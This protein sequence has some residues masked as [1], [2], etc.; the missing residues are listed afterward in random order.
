MRAP[1]Y[2]KDL[3]ARRR[4]GE[5]IGL[6][7]V[8]VH[9]W[10]GGRGVCRAPWRGARGR[11]DDTLP[12]EL[13]WSCAVALDCLVSWRLDAG[14]FRCRL[15]MLQA[16]GAASLW[17][18]QESGIVLIEP[19]ESKY[20]PPFLSVGEPVPPA[21]FK[22]ALREHRRAALMIRRGVWTPLFDDAREA[23]WAVLR[24]GRSGGDWRCCRSSRSKRGR[25]DA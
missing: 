3:I 11:S 15:T 8:G 12:H 19:F 25:H 13:D 2:A 21:L 10:H 7:V 5:R 9:D 6:L 22:R 14:V 1:A 23:E 18:E 16:A 4:K 24:S 17:C 20:W